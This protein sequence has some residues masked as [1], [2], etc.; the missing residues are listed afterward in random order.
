MKFKT[1]GLLT[2]YLRCSLEGQAKKEGTVLKRAI[3]LQGKLLLLLLLSILLLTLSAC[4]QDGVGETGGTADGTESVTTT[5]A[6]PDFPGTGPSDTEST[7]RPEDTEKP[8]TETTF[9]TEFPNPI[10]PD[11]TKR[12]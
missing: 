6:E 9:Y 2:E 1:R 10:E 3:H 11:G 7:P 4:L 12:Y 5:V 8:T